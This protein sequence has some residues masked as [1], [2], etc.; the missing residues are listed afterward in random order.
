MNV[1]TTLT[2]LHLVGLSHHGLHFLR[3]TIV[4]ITHSEERFVFDSILLYSI[5]L[6]GK[7]LLTASSTASIDTFAPGSLIFKK[8]ILDRVSGVW[9]FWMKSLFGSI[10]IFILVLI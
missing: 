3:A 7:W 9:G 1:D 4:L 6:V 8:N 5:V 2:V 10:F